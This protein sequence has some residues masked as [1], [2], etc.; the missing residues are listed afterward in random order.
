M[1]VMLKSGINN[2]RVNKGAIMIKSL[3]DGSFIA[4]TRCFVC[5]EGKD[6]L[7]HRYFKNIS[8][9]N[10]KAI[11]KEPCDKCKEYMAQGIIVISVR[12]NE[13]DRDNPYRT[14]GWWV[15]KEDA[16]KRMFHNI[17]FANNR[18]MF[19]ED[20][21]CSKIGLRKQNKTINDN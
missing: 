9:L 4:M 3:K 11:S 19:I 2:Q 5:G 12:D 13:P 15:V 10:N 1:N 6:I 21:A 20:S 8:A 17:D 14:G 16:L 18:V 7:L